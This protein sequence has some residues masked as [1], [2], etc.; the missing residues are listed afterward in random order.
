[1]DDLVRVIT[2]EMAE[3]EVH[4]VR[5]ELGESA[6]VMAASLR[7]CFDVCTQ[8][9]ALEG[10]KLEIVSTNGNSLNLKEVEVA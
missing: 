9:T 8:G 5:L 1:M 7:F 2:E 10:A 4:V 6:G 3:V